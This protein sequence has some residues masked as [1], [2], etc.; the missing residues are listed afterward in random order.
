MVK[1]WPLR[2]LHAPCSN[3]LQ[4][5]VAKAFLPQHPR[6]LAPRPPVLAR[7]PQPA[8][9]TWPML[10]GISWI[11]FLWDLSGSSFDAVLLTALIYKHIVHRMCWKNSTT[12]CLFIVNLT[13]GQAA[14]PGN[15]V[16]V[17]LAFTSFTIFYLSFY[18][19]WGEE[20]GD[21]QNKT[22]WFAPII[23]ESE[24]PMNSDSWDLCHTKCLLDINPNRWRHGGR[25]NVIGAL[26]KVTFCTS[27]LCFFLLSKLP[28]APGFCYAFG[29]S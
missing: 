19:L 6:P 2:S 15:G 11:L 20:C 7:P 3:S 9:F 26:H 8:L 1:I 5:T 28:H 23:S 18:K 4:R 29:F 13:V 12:S 10:S 24:F 14:L 17:I 21:M 22:W 25:H 27:D 16:I